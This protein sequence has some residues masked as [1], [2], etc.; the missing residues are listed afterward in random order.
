MTHE[1]IKQ[2]P[3]ADLSANGW[4]IEIALQLALL[5]EKEPREKRVQPTRT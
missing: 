4:L 2:K 1:E 5:K 3:A